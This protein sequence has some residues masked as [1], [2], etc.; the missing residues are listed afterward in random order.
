MTGLIVWIS[1]QCQAA[2][3]VMSEASEEDQ[4]ALTS[5]K[6]DKR[7][8][9]IPVRS[10]VLLGRF[11]PLGVVTRKKLTFYARIG[12]SFRS[13][14]TVRERHSWHETNKESKS[15]ILKRTSVIRSDTYGLTGYRRGG[16]TSQG[17]PSGG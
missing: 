1:S 15:D 14:L 6:H 2:G 8:R 3:W 13:W 10:T 9:L 5:D 7:E 12:V 4:P 16:R 11:V 17:L